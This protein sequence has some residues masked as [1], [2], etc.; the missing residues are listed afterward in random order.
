M[1]HWPSPPTPLP[2]AGEGRSASQCGSRMS[3]G[4]LLM[5]RK[6]ELYT[7]IGLLLMALGALAAWFALPQFQ[8]FASALLVNPLFW[9]LVI[10][11][12][13]M[14]LLLP[15]TDVRALLNRLRSLLPGRGFERSYLKAIAEQMART[16]A[17]LVISGRDDT[18]RELSLLSAFSQ[19]TLEPEDGGPSGADGTSVALFA[20]DIMIQRAGR[21]G[22][23]R[24]PRSRIEQALYVLGWLLAQAAPLAVALLLLYALLWSAASGL[25]LSVLRVASALVVAV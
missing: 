15:F 11:V 25:Q 2:S 24:G 9:P 14:A 1:G 10:V 7:I 16:P 4:E 12:V 23:G 5:E 13:V 21:M 8:S 6:V 19:L 17:L 3:G 22:R 18:R 20:D